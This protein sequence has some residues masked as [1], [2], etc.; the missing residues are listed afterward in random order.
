MYRCRRHSRYQLHA[1]MMPPELRRGGIYLVSSLLIVTL[2]RRSPLCIDLK[3]LGRCQHSLRSC[4]SSDRNR[5]RPVAVRPGSR[6]R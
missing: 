6:S 5:R 1:S 3:L 2:A 4:C